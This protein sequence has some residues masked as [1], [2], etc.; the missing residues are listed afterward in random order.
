MNNRINDRFNVNIHNRVDN[1]KL[2]VS[3]F[4]LIDL[5]VI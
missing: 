3:I 2:L 1:L 5:Y 4:K